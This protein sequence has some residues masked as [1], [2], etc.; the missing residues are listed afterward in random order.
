MARRGG[1]T[2]GRPTELDETRLVRMQRQPEVRESLA[3]LDEAVAT[4]NRRP[5][6]SWVS[7]T[8]TRRIGLSFI[9]A[10]RRLTDPM[11]CPPNF[12]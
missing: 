5:S 2:V 4:G 12:V 9:S 7:R 11:A 10:S 6:I 8:A 3:Q 1:I